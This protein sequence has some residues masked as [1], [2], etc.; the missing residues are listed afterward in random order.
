MVNKRDDEW[1]DEYKRQT[2]LKGPWLWP[3]VVVILIVVLAFFAS[4]CGP[5]KP[6]KSE[7]TDFGTVQSVIKAKKNSFLGDQWQI[8]TTKG[9]VTFRDDEFGLDIVKYKIKGKQVYLL[10]KAKFFIVGFNNDKKYM[11]SVGFELHEGE[12]K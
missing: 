7:C 5:N 3:L 12:V 4:G 9:I 11:N 6:K 1:L 8:V 2:S 10:G